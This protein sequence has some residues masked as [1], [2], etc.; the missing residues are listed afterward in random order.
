MDV[1]LEK[2]CQAYGSVRN[3]ANVILIEG[4]GIS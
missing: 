1:A 3:M 2:L 4:A